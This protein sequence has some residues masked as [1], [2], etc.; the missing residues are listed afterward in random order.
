MLFQLVARLV[1]IFPI[2]WGFY[3]QCKNQTQT[4]TAS[5]Q[6]FCWW[7]HLVNKRV[8]REKAKLAGDDRGA[9]LTKAQGRWAAVD[10]VKTICSSTPVSKDQEFKATQAHHN[11]RN[12]AG[13]NQLWP[14]L[15]QM[16]GSQF[17][18]NSMISLTHPVNSS[19]FRWYGVGAFSWTL[20]ISQ[21]WFLCHGFPIRAISRICSMSRSK[22]RLKLASLTWW[23]QWPLCLQDLSPV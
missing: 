9:T 10:E 16:F 21:S 7:K 14:L 20:N 6:K 3:K 23:L 15:R 2:Y 17:D 1:W 19:G 12:A 13:S 8:Q 5:Q 4:V 18:A 22:T 11:W